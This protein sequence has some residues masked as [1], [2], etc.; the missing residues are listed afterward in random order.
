MTRGSAPNFDLPARSRGLKRLLVICE[1]RDGRPIR[2]SL[3]LVS[4]ARSMMD[5]FPG[6]DDVDALIFGKLEDP[7]RTFGSCGAGTVY[8]CPA[9]AGFIDPHQAVGA[10]GPFLRQLSPALILC[11]HTPWGSEIAPRLSVELGAALISRCVG[12][13]EASDESLSALQSVQNGRLHRECSAGGGGPFI[14]SWQPESLGRYEAREGVSAHVVDVA[15]AAASRS[16]AVRSIRIVEGDPASMPL[17]QADRILAVGR[18]MDP[19]D[20]PALRELAGEIKASIGGTRPVIDA[21]S[22]PFERQIGQTGV[23]V[24]PSLLL[25]WGISGAN[26][27]TVGI[28]DAETIVC[29]NKDAQ[30]PMFML[31]DLGLVGDGK[32]ILR[33]VIE[34][35]ASTEPDA[36]SEEA[37]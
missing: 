10:L 32:K 19:E 13:L 3:D 1:I 31:S 27:F 7:G 2:P 21:G 18:G 12:V 8:Q 28:E 22:L 14:V 15:A 35:L 24:A 33:R 25:A 34:V 17:D 11:A 26:E 6:F 30:A 20:L 4:E 37:T 5:R 29:V 36:S 9:S 23:T 16:E